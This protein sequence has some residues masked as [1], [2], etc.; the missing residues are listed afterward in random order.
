LGLAQSLLQNGVRTA[1][2]HEL[3]QLESMNWENQLLY[4][5]DLVEFENVAVE[6][7]DFRKIVHHFREI[8]GYTEN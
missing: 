4:T 7:Q 6:V 2:F 5:D 8:H 3:R 1:S